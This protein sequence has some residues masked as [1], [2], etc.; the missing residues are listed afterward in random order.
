MYDRAT[1]N[2][3]PRLLARVA[4]MAVVLAAVGIIAC[5]SDSGESHDFDALRDACA[6]YS[7]CLEK[8]RG[9][10]GACTDERSEYVAKFRAAPET[11]SVR[12]Y[13]YRG[14]PVWTTVAPPACRHEDS[15][16]ERSIGRCLEEVNQ[17]LE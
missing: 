3:Q 5:A 9:D 1:M 6:E 14:N 15:R 13:D 2:R 4:I 16:V 12:H 7:K 11:R 8:H 17:G 10:C